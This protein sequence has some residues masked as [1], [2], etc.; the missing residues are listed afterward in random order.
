MLELRQVSCSLG[1]VER[2]HDVDIALH[3]GRAPAMIEAKSAGKSTRMNIH[4]S[5]R[6]GTVK[7][8]VILPVFDTIVNLTDFVASCM[9]EAIQRAIIIL[10][11]VL[12]REAKAG[13]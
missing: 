10:A 5:G 11:A 7:G 6:V 8:V 1:P 12:Q 13:T 3:R 2:L 9:N 4:G